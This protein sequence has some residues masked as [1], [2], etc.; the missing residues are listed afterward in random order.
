MPLLTRDPRLSARQAELLESWLP[1]AVTVRDHSWELAARAVL[2][3]TWS[4]EPFIIKA[5][6]GN[7]HHMEREIIAHDQWLTPWT[8]IGRTPVAVHKNAAARLLVTKYLPG[9]LVLGTKHADN[10]RTYQQAG[11]LL[12]QFHA[13]LSVRDPDDEAR[14][15]ARSIKWLDG[16]HRITPVTEAA[17]RAEIAS[18]PTPPTTLVPTHGDWQPRNWLIHEGQVSIIDLGRA[19]LRPAMTDLARLAA[20]NFARDPSLESA[21][22]RGYG[23]DPREPAAWHRVRIR[24]AIGTA[25]W[26]HQVGDEA[27]EAQGHEMIAAALAD[28]RGH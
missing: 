2:E 4:G 25:V 28:P 19:G 27:F 20:Q 21:F 17:L 16:S 11:E 26:A 13:Q 15:N 10:P 23:T 1:G 3:V 14:Q 8:S 9:E 5:G 18:W 6:S 24:E 7:D 22:F 12:S